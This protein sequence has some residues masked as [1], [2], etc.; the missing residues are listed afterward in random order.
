ME[1]QEM[2]DLLT[3][4]LDRLQAIKDINEDDP[5]EGRAQLA[6][7]YNLVELRIEMVPPPPQ[8]EGGA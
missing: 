4:I 5:D 6:H 7:L 3:D 1:E 2:R 8:Y